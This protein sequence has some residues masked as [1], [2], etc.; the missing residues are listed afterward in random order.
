MALTRRLIF[1]R[2]PQKKGNTMTSTRRTFLQ[3][4]AVGAATLALPLHHLFGQDS[5]RGYKVGICDWNVRGSMAHP[6]SFAVAKELGFQGVEVSYT[7][8]GKFTLRNSKENRQLYKDAAK[9]ANMEFSSLAMGLLNGRPFAREADA[10][11]WVS[12][13]MDAMHDLE[14]D[15]VLMA[16]FSEGNLV[17]KPEDQKSTIEKLKRLAPQAEKLGKTLALETYLN[18]EDHLRIIDA[19]GSDAVK[20]Y[21]DI[22]NSANMGYD[23]FKEMEMLGKKKLIVQV[24]LKDDHKRLENS[25]LDLNRVRKTLE[26]IEYYGWLV[27]ESAVEGDWRESQAANAHFV[28]NLFEIKT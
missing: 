7:L 3:S 15:R 2:Y 20:V 26:E 25:T 13:C 12:D 8:E 24:H 5:E 27:V 16:F 14:V 11:D 28:R 23:I 1:H 4:A 19:V 21:Y 17:D 6:D 22:Q 10:E 18:A 9:K